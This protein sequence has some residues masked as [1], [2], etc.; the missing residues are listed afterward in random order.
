MKLVVVPMLQCTGTE[1]KAEIDPIIK[2]LDEL[3][4]CPYRN[5]KRDTPWNCDPFEDCSYCPF[6]QANAKVRE[7]LEI[8]KKIEVKI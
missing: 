8:I 2:T 4:L 3:D 6:G 7:A 1:Y 5:E